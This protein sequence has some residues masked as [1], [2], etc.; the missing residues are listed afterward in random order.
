MNS[1]NSARIVEETTESISIV[2]FESI[3]HEEV[4]EIIS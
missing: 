2:R 1:Q 3:I 4:K